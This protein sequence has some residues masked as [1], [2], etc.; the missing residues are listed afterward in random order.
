M[1]GGIVYGVR[2]WESSLTRRYGQLIVGLSL[3]MLPLA[4]AGS[5]G[6]AFAA[7]LLAG[8]M[9]APVL[10]T[11]FRMIGALAPPG[12]ATESFTWNTSAI[13]AGLAS[14]AALAGALSDA[15]A[16]GAVFVMACG[17]GLSAAFF[18]VV[19]RHAVALPSAA[20]RELDHGVS[21]D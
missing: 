19:A 20:G 14:G 12:R 8:T 17:V 15:V 18:L 10:A 7:A 4:A 9:T 11:E 21:L 3:L 13:T 5:V 16:P 2:E 1:A 6:A